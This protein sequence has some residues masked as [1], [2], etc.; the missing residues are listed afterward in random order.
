MLDVPRQALEYTFG[1]AGSTRRITLHE[2]LILYS[3][4]KTVWTRNVAK[5]ET[6]TTYAALSVAKKISPQTWHT[7]SILPIKPEDIAVSPNAH[8]SHLQWPRPRSP[9]QPLTSHYPRT[10]AP[11][12][13][14][15]SPH[16]HNRLPI[17]ALLLHRRQKTQ[18]DYFDWPASASTEC[19]AQGVPWIHQGPDHQTAMDVCCAHVPGSQQIESYKQCQ[20]LHRSFSL[21][22]MGLMRQNMWNMLNGSVA[23]SNQLSGKTRNS[24]PVL[25]PPFL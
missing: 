4:I 24:P 1:R 19:S 25:P 6:C 12:P 21:K 16:H 14:P 7:K 3:R 8:H 5:E 2:L 23:C 9:I 17:P 18:R 13:P 15:H 10:A 20:R 22:M 11:P